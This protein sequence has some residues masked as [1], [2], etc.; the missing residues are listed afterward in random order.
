MVRVVFNIFHIICLFFVLKIR[1]PPVSPRPYTL[2]PYTKLFRSAAS[3]IDSELVE[4]VRRFV[5][6]RIAPHSAGWN[7]EGQVPDSVLAEMGEMGL[8]GD[9]KSTRLNSSH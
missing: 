5:Q 8:F 9:R 6:K 3:N 4:G 2:F 7:R 1:R